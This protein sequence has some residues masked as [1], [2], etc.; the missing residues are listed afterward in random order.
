[1]TVLHATYGGHDVVNTVRAMVAGG[2]CTIPAS[3]VSP[4]P[5]VKSRGTFR[6]VRYHHP[7]G[8]E[9]DE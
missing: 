1:M 5:R 3:N 2:N 8:C 9:V 6:V 4:V 7:S